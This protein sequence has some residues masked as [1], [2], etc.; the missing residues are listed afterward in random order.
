MTWLLLG[1]A[2]L[3]IAWMALMATLYMR[4][5]ARIFRPDRDTRRDPSD[6]GPGWQRV[7]MTTPDGVDLD[8]WYKAAE[9]AGEDRAILFLHGNSGNLST[10]VETLKLYASTG[11]AVLAIDYRGYGQSGGHPSES[12]LFSDALTAWQWLTGPA[13]FRPRRILV[14]GRSLGGPVAAW[15]AARSGPGALALESTFSSMPELAQKLYPL[16]PVRILCRFHLD[17]RGH[18]AK[19]GCPV[20]VVHSPEDELIPIVHAERLLKTAGR[21]GRFHGVTGPHAAVSTGAPGHYLRG[22]RRFIDDVLPAA[23]RV[24]RAEMSG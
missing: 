1:A 8:A 3:F 21:R 11:L 2:A 16:L 15:L 22:L 24:D 20:L 6:A 23:Q 18:L 19:T 14:I 5:S 17:T 4:Q 10:R 13:G 9:D 7:P 12:G